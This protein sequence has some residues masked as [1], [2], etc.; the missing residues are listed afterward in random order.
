[1][2]TIYIILSAGP[3]YCA[4]LIHL[5]LLLSAAA[6]RFNRGDSW[7]SEF[8]VLCAN[9]KK[10]LTGLELK[11]QYNREYYNKVSTKK[12]RSKKKI[13]KK[14]GKGKGYRLYL[15]IK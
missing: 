1:M 11:Q 13:P 2:K 15:T 14:K 8:V 3:S 5:Y 6:L 10:T 9:S 7:S 12:K 4:Y